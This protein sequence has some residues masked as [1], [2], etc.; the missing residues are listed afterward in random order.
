[1]VGASKNMLSGNWSIAYVRIDIF[2]EQTNDELNAALQTLDLKNRTGIVLDLRYNPGGLVTRVVDV[3]GHFIK[4]GVVLTL[5]DNKGNRTSESVR[6]NGVFTDLPMVVLV[7]QYT[8]SG[9]EV[10]SGVL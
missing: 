6:P 9:S 8:A 1:M 5:V 2:D 10:L 4:E 3:A 7:K